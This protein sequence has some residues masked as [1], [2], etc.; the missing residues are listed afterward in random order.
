MKIAFI[1]PFLYRYAR[2]IERYTVNLAS[3]LI[4]DGHQVDIITWRW[5]E[6]LLWAELNQQVNVYSLPTSRYFAASF[7]G[8][9]IAWHLL[10]NFYDVVVVYFA[11]YGEASSFR[12]L[13]MLGRQPRFTIVLHFPYSQVPHRYHSLVRSGLV[14]SAQQVVAVSRFVAD[15]A[16]SILGRN[17]AVI[18]HGVDVAHFAPNP[19][20]RAEIRRQWDI[21]LEAPLLLSIA[22]L[23][24]RKGMQW[25]LQALPE[26]ARQWPY[27]RYI[28]VGDGPLESELRERTEKL[29][30]QT[31]IRFVP[32]TPNVLPFYQ[33]ADLFVILARGEASSLVSLEALACEVPVLASKHPPFD[34]LICSDWGRQ[35]DETSPEA[36]VSVIAELIPD[37]EKRREMGRQGRNYILSEHTWPIIA[38]QYSTLLS[39]K[40]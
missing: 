4:D 7:A 27:V 23:E 16:R 5:S 11:E 1:H 17:S 9:L 22:A 10:N 35:V 40:A 21:P 12:L 31:L 28:I 34:E 19:V 37:T 14:R 38:N 30:V 32:A 8:P 36:I 15:D 6:R 24:E 29:G 18:S 26:V 39:D 3:S 20:R 25:M 13:K 2:G 33:A